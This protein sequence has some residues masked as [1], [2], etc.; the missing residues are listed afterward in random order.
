MWFLAQYSQIV[1]QTPYFL[2]CIITSNNSIGK[3]VTTHR[4]TKS[5]KTFILCF[6]KEIYKD[7]I[8]HY[9]VWYLNDD[10]GWY[11]C[12]FNYHVYIMYDCT[13]KNNNGNWNFAQASTII[14]FVKNQLKLFTISVDLPFWPHIKE[15]VLCKS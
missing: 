15:T 12:L 11:K 6:A 10:R 3:I 14:S 13:C 9:N 1:L 5:V 2:Q 8:P 4:D 7:M